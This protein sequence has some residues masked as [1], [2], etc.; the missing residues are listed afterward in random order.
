MAAAKASEAS[1]GSGFSLS[2]KM[3]ATLLQLKEKPEPLDAS[4][5]LAAAICH[6][7]NHGLQK[8]IKQA[9]G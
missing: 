7:H 1:N 2:C 4:D 9:R 3:V 5:A 6:V 8:K